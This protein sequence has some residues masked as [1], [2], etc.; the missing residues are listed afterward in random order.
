MTIIFTESDPDEGMLLIV[1]VGFTTVT[2]PL[3]VPLLELLDE[4][5]SKSSIP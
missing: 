3:E 1:S 2:F 4:E 5:V